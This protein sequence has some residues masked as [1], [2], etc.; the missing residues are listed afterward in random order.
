MV[1]PRLVADDRVIVEAGPE[2]LE[3]S[4]PDALRGLL[5]VR[6]VGIIS[7]PGVERARLVLVADIAAQSDIERLPGA[8][9]MAEICGR[10]VARMSI[11]PFEASAPLKLLLAL[12]GISL[13]G[14]DG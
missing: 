13:Y 1:A 7:V 10:Q 2:G 8:E 12:A 9:A 4:A 5:E 3:V 6:G 11:A 14:Q